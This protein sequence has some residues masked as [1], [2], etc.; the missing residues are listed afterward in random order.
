MRVTD[1]RH[2]ESA[3]QSCANRD[4][5]ALAWKLRFRRCRGSVRIAL[6]TSGVAVGMCGAFHQ[7]RVKHMADLG[8]A[9]VGSLNRVQQAS[10]L[11]NFGAIAVNSCRDCWTI[12]GSAQLGFRRDAPW[13]PASACLVMLRSLADPAS[14]STSA[15]KATGVTMRVRPM[16]PRRSSPAR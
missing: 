3:P 12:G 11:F 8:P 14:Q 2:A 1:Q 4:S 13:H 9:H 10:S 16:W 7:V 5:T 6:A 15:Q